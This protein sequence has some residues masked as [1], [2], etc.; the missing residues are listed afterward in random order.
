MKSCLG[1][2]ALSQRGPNP[3]AQQSAGPE[4]SKA[5]PG[6][7]SKAVLL[8][9]FSHQDRTLCFGIVHLPH[10]W[11]AVGQL[12]QLCAR[13]DAT[14]YWV[15]HD[16]PSRTQDQRHLGGLVHASEGFVQAAVKNPHDQSGH[17]ASCAL[18]LQSFLIPRGT[19]Y[20]DRAGP[21]P[22]HPRIR[23]LRLALCRVAMSI[24]TSYDESG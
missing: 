23:Y 7:H 5:A 21:T 13:V 22:R 11:E 16:V 19:S 9:V 20:L 14:V 3:S 24:N 15:L 18:P 17:L 6:S 8:R 10:V 12:L 2:C 1:I 4:L